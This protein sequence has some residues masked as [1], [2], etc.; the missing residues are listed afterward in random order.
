M[1]KR[2]PD[3]GLNGSV[4]ASGG[5]GEGTLGSAGAD[6]S[7]R[8]GRVSL[9]GNTSFLWDA[10]QEFFT[11]YRRVTGTEGITELPTESLRDPVQRNIVVRLGIDYHLNDRTTLGATVG[12]YDNKA[13]LDARSRLT[14]RQ[15]GAST[16]YVQSDIDRINHWRHAMGNV[17]V[18]HQTG[19]SGTFSV[20]LDYL[21]YHARNPADYV[22]T[23][24]DVASGGVTEE[25]LGSRKRTPL[26]ILV[27]KA[28]YLTGARGPWEFGAGAKGAFSRFTNEARFES[29]VQDPW[30]AEAGLDS[31][32]RLSEDVLAVYSKASYQ[33]GES[34]SL[35]MGLRYE[36]TDSN[37]DS[38]EVQ[39]LVDRR[40]GRLFPSLAYSH[41][42]GDAYQINGSYTRRITRPS[43]S[44]LA[45]YLLFQ[46]PYT[47][48]SGNTTLQPAINQSVKLAVTLKSLLASL[49][50]AREDSTITHYQSRLIPGRNIQVMAP[51]N[52]RRTQTV[53][54]LLA[55]PVTLTSWWT[56][57]NN[58]MI[59]WQ[60]VD[61]YRN[62]LP[63]TI[64]QETLRLN[65]IQ[66][67][68][69]P[70]DLNLE[71]SGFYQ[72]AGLVGAFEL[73]PIWGVNV[74]VQRTLPDGNG[75][76]T[77]SVNDVFDS[78]QYEWTTASPEDAFYLEQLFD[79]TQR[80]FRLTYS[81][82]F[83]DGKSTQKRA[84]ASEE[85]SGRVEP[86]Q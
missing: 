23:T 19:G 6:V 82:R 34:V 35:K 54:A 52:F 81:L 86:Q 49:E 79:L 71:L 67:I 83:G 73:K 64:R 17:N 33:A 41:R 14:V 65:A 30:L 80:T 76:L 2:N 77:L 20:D 40:F 69:L 27:A 57:Q 48:F 72:S 84:T 50:Y 58:V 66:N 63:A 37:L 18:R 22:N 3:D 8:R 85:E 78:V 70:G 53:T 75:R 46:D 36:L 51:T 47:F 24:T 43:F 10:R 5:Y 13:T 61:G 4:T 28:D 12:T 7:Y 42:L 25:E 45:P 9:H 38:D 26:H 55:L 60:E 59:T 68:S 44:D 62:G 21:Y 15:D 16:E 1:L 39:N 74:G 11:N 31:K 56:T 29:L 32:T